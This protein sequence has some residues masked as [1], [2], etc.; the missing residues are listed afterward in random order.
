MVECIDDPKKSLREGRGGQVGGG[1][2]SL[3]TR[4]NLRRDCERGATVDRR[5]GNEA[6]SKRDSASHLYLLGIPPF[7]IRAQTWDSQFLSRPVIQKKC[8]KNATRG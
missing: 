2:A 7:A 4:G 1:R 3:R 8:G 5:S 6:L